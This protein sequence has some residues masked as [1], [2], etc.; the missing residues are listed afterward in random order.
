MDSRNWKSDPSLKPSKAICKLPSENLEH[1]WSAARMPQV[2]GNR[3]QIIQV[4]Q[5]LVSNAIKYRR[6]EIPPKIHL[7][8]QSTT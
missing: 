8:A 5:N 7:S 1:W 6:P 2:F 3:V 4:F